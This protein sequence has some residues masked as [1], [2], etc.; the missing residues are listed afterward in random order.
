MV[1]RLEN[2]KLDPRA[3]DVFI[4]IARSQP[5]ASCLIVGG[6]S[7]LPVMKARV[8]AAGLEDRFEFTDYVSYG[9]LPGYYA[10]MRVF[11]A[12]VA[13]ESFGQVTPFAMSMGLP[14]VGFRVG[15][16]P[17]QLQQPA[18]LADPGDV[19]GLAALACG[20]LADPAACCRIGALNRERAHQLYSVDS[21]VEAYQVLYREHLRVRR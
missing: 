14:V 12:P 19:A 7:Q 4:T 3:I 5:E 13:A 16:L 8:R 2:D 11:V 17:E 18:L 15:A 6:G 9:D 20:L 10:R 1:Y 21:M